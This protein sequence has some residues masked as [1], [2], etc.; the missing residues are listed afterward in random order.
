[1]TGALDRKWSNTSRRVLQDIRRKYFIASSLKD[2]LE[3]V[4][5]QNLID[6]IKHAYFF[7]IFHPI[8]RH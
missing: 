3:S 8:V 1:M 2:I 5:N 4:D 7:I 6:L